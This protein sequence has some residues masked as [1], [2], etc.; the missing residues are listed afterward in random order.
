MGSTCEQ[1]MAW[2]R[3]YI[4]PSLVPKDYT[5]SWVPMHIQAQTF[6]RLLATVFLGKY[7]FCVLPSSLQSALYS[8]PHRTSWCLESVA[9]TQTTKALTTHNNHKVSC[10]S[11][12]QVPCLTLWESTTPV[13]LVIYSHYSQCFFF[14]VIA[15]HVLVSI[16]SSKLCGVY[17]SL[18]PK[19]PVSQAK[20]WAVM[21][22]TGYSLAN[23]HQSL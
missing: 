1:H 7:G 15:T 16:T 12:C 18:N 3:G 10:H 21:L 6:S 8:C 23:N 4:V 13:Y 11:A 17:D 5:V 19:Q 2:K 20:E 9:T 14:S 22:A